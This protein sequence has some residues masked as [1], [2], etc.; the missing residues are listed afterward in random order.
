M[1]P[2]ALL[3]SPLWLFNLGV[4]TIRLGLFY[5]GT[6]EISIATFDPYTPELDAALQN[7]KETRF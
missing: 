4:T 7:L 2:L 6:E 5:N 3:P 1:L